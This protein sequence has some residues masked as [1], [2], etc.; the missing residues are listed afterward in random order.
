MR[1]KLGFISFLLFVGCLTFAQDGAK[2]T[3][4]TSKTK[5]GIHQRVR[6]EYNINKQGAD[7]F[8]LPEFKNFEVV[9]GPSTSVSQSWINGKS[10]YSQGYTYI[11]KPTKIGTFTLPPGTIEYNGKT[12]SSNT[13]VI[14]VV[15]EDEIPKDPNDP[16]FIASQ[17]LHLVT[18]ISKRNPY[19][20]EPIYVEYRLYFTRN[21]GL[22]SGWNFKEIPQYEGFW[23]HD[24][25]FDQNEL[26]ETTYKGQPYR[27]VVLKKALLI[28]QKS[29]KLN[30]EPFNLDIN[31]QVPTGRADFFGNPI[32]RNVTHSTHSKTQR[33]KVKELPLEGKP[34]NFSGAVGDFELLVSLTKDILRANESTQLK[35][36]V[37]GRGNLQLFDLPKIETPVEL[38]VYTPERKENVAIRSNGISG[39]ITDSYTIVPEYRGKYKIPEIS[40][41]YFSLKEK[42]YKTITNKALVIDVAEGKALP[43]GVSQNVAEA[44][45]A[46]VQQKVTVNKDNNFQYISTKTNF[47]PIVKK[48]F[49]RSKL[50]YFLLLFPFFMIPLGIL[51][52]YIKE[53]RDKDVVGQRLRNADKKARKFLAQAKKQMDKKEGFYIALEKALHNFLK[54]KLN[55][56]TTEISKERITEIL[57]EKNVSPETIKA[58]ISVLNDCDF[59]R[60]APT[61]EAMM[62]QDYEKAKDVITQIDKQI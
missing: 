36:T 9:G 43:G 31:V 10:T 57:E 47:K 48:D 24:I 41:S 27:Y 49:Y 19:L 1:I 22:S 52:G 21:I 55:I 54:A 37:K 4:T 28:P 26:K 2:L 23:N 5:M 29:G 46:Q 34:A 51:L 3:A 50:Y 14:D 30:I 12:L 6:I 25:E 58:F 15:S 8:A 20:G 39:S 42:K 53:K 38:E 62:Q 60:Y 40:F 56:E 16:S 7:N 11:L 59:A 35:T 13:V 61:N 18:E 33:I 32:L 45:Q 17:N 44:P